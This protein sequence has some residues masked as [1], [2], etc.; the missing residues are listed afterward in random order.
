MYTFC[1]FIDK[2]GWCFIKLS[3]KHFTEKAVNGSGAKG[4]PQRAGGSCEPGAGVLH[5]SPRS[6]PVE[7][8]V[9]RNGF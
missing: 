6:F 9:G 4:R 8:L 5:R 1:Y 2:S 3:A 7:R